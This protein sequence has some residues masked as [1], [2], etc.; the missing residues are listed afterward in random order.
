MT[1]L[2]TNFPHC[3]KH[4]LESI[5]KLIMHLN[6]ASTN[7]IIFQEYDYNQNLPMFPFDPDGPGDPLSPTGPA[8]PG[9]PS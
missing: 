7:N 9:G 5:I 1:T 4:L 2:F 3:A 8:G 6:I